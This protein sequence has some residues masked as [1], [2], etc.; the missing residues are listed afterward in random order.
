[1]LPKHL[2]PMEPTPGVEPEPPL[3]GGASIINATR[4]MEQGLAGNQHLQDIHGS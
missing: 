4:T 2:E 1:M 3:K